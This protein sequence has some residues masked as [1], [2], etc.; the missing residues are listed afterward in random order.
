LDSA[1]RQ[2]LQGVD[3]ATVLLSPVTWLR[4]RLREGNSLPA[5]ITIITRLNE[6]T[7]VAEQFEP[8]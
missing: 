4:R 1:E 2:L 6:L 8:L 5:D 7:I 3:A